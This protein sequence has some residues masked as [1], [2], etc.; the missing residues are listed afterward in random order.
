MKRQKKVF[1]LIHNQRTKF[2]HQVISDIAEGSKSEVCVFS[3]RQ[4]DFEKAKS[5]SINFRIH[6]LN[7]SDLE[8][9]VLKSSPEEMS[10]LIELGERKVGISS[11]RILM[12]DERKWGRGF[13][14]GSWTWFGDPIE[15]KIIKD[16]NLPSEMLMK[17]FDF[18]FDK[19]KQ[20]KPD[21][22]LMGSASGIFEGSLFFVAKTM[23][24]EVLIN[25][26]SKILDDCFFWTDDWF[27]QN[28]QGLKL[29]NR[30]L[31]EKKSGTKRSINFV[32]KFRNKPKPVAYISDNWRKSKS[33]VFLK[34]RTYLGSLRA[35]VLFKLGLITGARPVDPV[36]RIKADFRAACSVKK[37][38]RYVTNL[39]AVELEKL[40][41]VYFPLHKEPE[42]ALNHLCP[43]WHDQLHLI[44]WI[45][46]NLP[47]GIKLVVKDHRFND[48]RRVEEFY[49]SLTMLPDAVLVNSE[50][51]QYNLI[52]YSSAVLS[53]NGT[54]AFEALIFDKPA[55]YLGKTFYDFDDNPAKLL[56]SA[57]LDVALRK[58][59][60]DNKEP[61]NKK[62]SHALELL[63]ESEF[64]TT[65]QEGFDSSNN[66]IFDTIEKYLSRN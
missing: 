60:V 9:R 51:D 62:T 1:V 40:R 8:K 28:I 23:G 42:L 52:K 38:R 24:I 49:R 33:A 29:T 43:M 2:F 31:L 13:R 65:F 54:S 50:Y 47:Y 39:P 66:Y 37:M 15:K 53:I 17:A 59:L 56:N 48:G 21:M 7:P 58:A 64:L 5:K 6:T 16:N 14:N 26:R 46:A 4:Q 22:V 34:I 63:V 61:E 11:K 3:N 20:A 44:R 32:E 45:V 27:E 10:S 57:N 36:A 35:S 19:V 41:Y 30:M 12:T 55:I 18:W 25:R